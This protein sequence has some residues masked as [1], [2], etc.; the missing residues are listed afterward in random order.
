[1]DLALAKQLSRPNGTRIVLCFLDG[2][3][4]L[5]R[6]GTL[7][8]ELEAADIANLDRLA[9]R[10]ECGFTQ[11]FPASPAVTPTAD[12]AYLALLGYDAGRDGRSRELPPFEETWSVRAVALTVEPALARIARAA[13][14][15][16]TEGFSGVQAQLAFVTAR[17]RDFDL[18]ILQEHGT[19]LAARK[20]D[21]DG[22]CRALEQFDHAIPEVLA[23]GPEVFAVAGARS[24]PSTFAGPSWHPSPFLLHSEHCRDGNAS[25]FNEQE[26][27][28]GTLG[29]MPA[30][31]AIPLAL[32]HAR[33]LGREEEES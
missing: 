12:E 1:V 17:W 23:L 33:R 29:I 10:S 25:H 13:G 5:A 28:R 22:A 6:T 18:F 20:G 30:S 21:F 31:E 4:G 16:E 2:L 8:S 19:A 11:T 24:M 32:A 26:V 27:L 15:E 9:P 14:I 3:G 7:R